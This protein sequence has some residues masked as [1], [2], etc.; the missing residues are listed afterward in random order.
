MAAWANETEPSLFHQFTLAVAVGQSGGHPSATGLGTRGP[1]CGLGLTLHSCH[2]H[3]F[4]WVT[5]E[6]CTRHYIQDKWCQDY[7]TC[8]LVALLAV[9]RI[10]VLTRQRPGCSS[11]L[12]AQLVPL[13]E[14]V[15]K[16]AAVFSVLLHLFLHHESLLGALKLVTASP[17]YLDPLWIRAAQLGQ[18]DHVGAE[19]DATNSSVHAGALV[20]TVRTEVLSILVDL[21]VVLAGSSI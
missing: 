21:V 18:N 16:H 13:S 4:H 8:H 11:P 9:S 12:W 14:V 19:G 7:G 3:T 15:F 17:G 1:G 5:P 2:Q 20:F 6:S 10:S